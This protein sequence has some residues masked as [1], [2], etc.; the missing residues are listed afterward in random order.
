MMHN[1]DRVTMYWEFVKTLEAP[2]VVHVRTGDILVKGNIFGQV[3]IR[4]FSQQVYK[5]F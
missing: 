2:R 1:S 4:F 5:Y 3:T